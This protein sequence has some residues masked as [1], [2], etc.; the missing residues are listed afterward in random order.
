MVYRTHFWSKWGLQT[1]GMAY[2]GLH[3]SSPKNAHSYSPLFTQKR[4]TMPNSRKA[5]GELLDSSSQSSMRAGWMAVENA[6]LPSQRPG[7][8]RRQKRWQGWWH[9]SWK[10]W[11]SLGILQLCF[12][13][14]SKISSIVQAS[15]KTFEGETHHWCNDMGGE[16]WHKK[17][18]PFSHTKNIQT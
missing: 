5:R 16:Q 3:H 1:W 9:P 11:Q 12:M 18:R 14:V 6:M 10:R 7:R 15:S 17:T 13:K 8:P 2:S 4:S